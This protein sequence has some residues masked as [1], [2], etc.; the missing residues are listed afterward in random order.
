MSLLSAHGLVKHVGERVILGGVSITLEDRDRVGLIGRNGTG[1][2]TLIRILT[3]QEE[4]EDGQIQTR[5]GLTMASVDQVPRLWPG[6]TVDDAVRRGLTHRR[7]VEAA[8]VALEAEMHATSGEGLD[9]LVLRQAE[10][11]HE[12]E[13]LGGYI[14]DHAAD[15]VLDALKAPPRHR[16]LDTCSLGEQRRV[17]LAVGLLARPDLLV[18]DE[19]TNHLDV[20]TIEWLQGNLQSYPG[21][22]LLVTHDR[23][24]LDEVADHIGELDRGTLRVY[25]GNYTDYLVKKAEREAIEAKT[26]HNRLRAIEQELTW[27]RAS[28]P[29]RTT[30]QKARLKRFDE[31][32]KDRP[33]LGMGQATF[34]LPHPP[35]IGKTIL[36][37]KGVTKGFG[38]RTLIERLDLLLKKGDRIGIVGPNGAGKTTLLK[39]IT[40]ELSPDA[41]EIVKGQNT[42]IV[43]A[44]QARSDL[45]DANTVLEEVAGDSDKVWVG[46]QPVQ[47]QSFLDQL[48]FDSALQRTKVAALSGGERSRVSLA[49]ALR[50]AAGQ[51][52]H[53]RRA[54]QRPRPRHPAGARGGAPRVP[55]LRPDRE[56]RP[57]LPRP[58]HHRGARLRGRGPGGALRGEPPALPRSPRRPEDRASGASRPAEGRG[59][60]QGSSEA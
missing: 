55:R 4:P 2:S 22:L 14:Q 20:E 54:D 51:P 12:L 28:A 36:E 45:D 26:E 6:A 42:E 33:V 53:P 41:G 17:F 50:V 23:Y 48:L 29:A 19:P 25:D 38:E 24:F 8:L 58:G 37:L 21:A 27:V 30:K 40:G 47:V 43:Y 35:R 18:L 10:L 15:A 39:M 49:K 46:D 32:V 44:D 60:G 56:P 5:R 13:R 57:V 31:L 34:R 7:E 52:A 3:G 1:K 11:S 9:A 16:V 59:A